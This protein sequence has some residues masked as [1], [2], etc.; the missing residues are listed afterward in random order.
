MNT[1]EELQMSVVKKLKG[2]ENRMD[3]TPKMAKKQKMLKHN[4][5]NMLNLKIFVI[6]KVL[7]R[8]YLYHLI[9]FQN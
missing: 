8:K 5:K 6:L 1:T 4:V 9:R 7:F 3:N 2:E